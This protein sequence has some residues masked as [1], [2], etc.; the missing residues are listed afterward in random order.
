MKYK[1]GFTI[2]EITVTVAII[3]ILATFVGM[4]LTGQQVQARDSVRSTKVKII[5]DAL[6][7]Y[8]DKHGEYPSV[9]ALLNTYS[10]NTGT[11]VASLLSLNEQTTLV[12]PGAGSGTTNSIASS[13]TTNDTIAYVASSAVGNDNCQSSAQGGCDQYTLSY[14]KES[15]GSTVTVE[16]QKRINIA[17]DVNPLQAPAK[18]TI[19][20]SQSDDSLVASSST[21]A[22]STSQSM[23]PRYAFKTQT[24]T[25]SWSAWSAWQTSSSYTLTSNINATSYSFQ[26]HVRCE[27]SA[28]M[29]DTSTDSDATSITYYAV[30]STPTTPTIA[31]TLSGSNA[32]ATASTTA[33]NVGT[34]QYKIDQRT[35]DGSWTNGSWSTA[36]SLSVAAADGVKYGFRATTRC[37]NVT[38][39]ATSAASTE[40]TYV[41]PITAP[42]APTMSGTGPTWSWSAA[43]CPASTSASYQYRFT[44][45]STSNFT[46]SW[47]L[48]SWITTSS[49]SVTNSAA[50][51]Q[52]VKYGIDIQQMCSNANAASAWGA[53]NG[54][55]TFIMPV[56]HAYVSHW[57]SMILPDGHPK[58]LIKT[59]QGGNPSNTGVCASGLTRQTNLSVKWYT[60]TWE[61]PTAWFTGTEGYTQTFT[62]HTLLT[63][64]DT[65]EFGTKTRCVN[66]STGYATDKDGNPSLNSPFDIGNLINSSGKYLISCKPANGY[67]SY[68]AGGYD[69][70][71]TKN[72]TSTSILNC[73]ERSTGIDTLNIRNTARFTFG[74]ASPCW[75]A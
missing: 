74:S 15:D 37:V 24:G 4:S 6:E 31:A 33:C 5:A 46:G 67:K 66:N 7:R 75:S 68:C 12:M 35:N 21:P 71:G 43:A 59:Y 19:T 60:T 9:R 73:A 17:T 48:G 18:P 56:T 22:C 55:A 49:T 58:V 64:T 42:G 10:D 34:A 30:P 36:A 47:T 38:Q 32:V 25:G 23:T 2:I 41:D 8:Y 28:A 72:S 61:G 45:N 20:A 63:D 13:I 62:S 3:A 16:S 70:G 1:N 52:G 29:S 27:S 40:A 69:L 57:S 51:S 53:Q 65:A 11:A 14:K 54:G 39:T 50:T 44:Y 26:V